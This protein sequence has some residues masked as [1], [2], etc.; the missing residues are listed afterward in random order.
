MTG[1]DR[2][3]AP[4]VLA[5]GAP[6]PVPALLVGRLAVDYRYSGLVIGTSLAAHVLATAV[7]LNEQAACRAVG[8]TALNATARTWWKRLGFDPFDPQDPDQFDLYLRTS[9]IEVTLRRV[10]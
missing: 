1:I 4:D 7:E 8:V 5:K 9:D 10:R 2:S 3:A 6:D